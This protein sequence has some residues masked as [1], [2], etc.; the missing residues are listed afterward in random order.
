MIRILQA[1]VNWYYATAYPVSQID[2]VHRQWL[3]MRRYYG[4]KGRVRDW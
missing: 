4:I 1:I 2:P 3:A